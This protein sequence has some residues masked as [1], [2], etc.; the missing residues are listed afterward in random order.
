[1]I[2]S[3]KTF[4]EFV[5]SNINILSHDITSVIDIMPCITIDKPLAYTYF[6]TLFFIWH[7]VWEWNNA[8]Q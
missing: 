4:I 2:V 5:S 6:V 7:R 1:M 3:E 8:M